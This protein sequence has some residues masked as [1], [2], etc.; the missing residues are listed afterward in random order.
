MQA[1]KRFLARDAI[2]RMAPIVVAVLAVSAIHSAP[3]SSGKPDVYH[4]MFIRS[5]PGQSRLLE[6][7]FK[8]HISLRGGNG[9]SLALHNLYGEDWDYLL[10]DDVGKQP[11]IDSQESPIPASVRD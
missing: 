4:L 1:A 6:N 2:L 5:T 8:D 7:Y 9:R 3:Q 10:I 11:S